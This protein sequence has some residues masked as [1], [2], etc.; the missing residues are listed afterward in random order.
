M[1]KILIPIFALCASVAFGADKIETSTT[2]VKTTTSTGT[3]TEYAPGKTF[4]IKE[5]AGPVTYR[6]GE[7]IV[8][9]TKSGKALTEDDVRARI[10]VGIPVSVHYVTEG[11][12]RIINR[13]EI[14]D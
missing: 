13:V 3:V 9:V 7:K 6:Y 12:N 11:E 5:S 2:T 8:Y 10:K 14:D 4:I 1:K